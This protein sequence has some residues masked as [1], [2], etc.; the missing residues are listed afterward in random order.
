L[1]LAALSQV[2]A[3]CGGGDS[4]GMFPAVRVHP[5]V[6][7][8]AL[9]HPLLDAQH[10]D[11]YV[12][13][14][15]QT[16]IDV[17]AEFTLTTVGC[18]TSND[19]S[20]RDSGVYWGAYRWETS[21]TPCAGGSL[22]ELD[23]VTISFHV[24]IWAEWYRTFLSGDLDVSSGQ[25]RRINDD[26]SSDRINSAMDTG[27]PGPRVDRVALLHSEQFSG[28]EVGHFERVFSRSHTFE[29]DGG[30]W[31]VRQNLPGN[32]LTSTG[33]WLT[34]RISLYVTACETNN[35][36]ACGDAGS[37]IAFKPP[38]QSSYLGEDASGLQPEPGVGSSGRGLSA[39]VDLSGWWTFV[40][41][42]DDAGPVCGDE[43]PYE[44]QVIIVHTNES[45]TVSGLGDGS[46]AWQ[47]TFDGLTA[48]FSG[49]RTED[50]AEGGGITD[51][52]FELDLDTTG[53]VL[54]G[55]EFWSW[56]NADEGL[57]CSDKTSVVTAERS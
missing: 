2:A 31:F 14:D 12:A 39:A 49:D 21:T 44:R 28:V 4:A 53:T 54:A 15:D 13:I 20:T 52:T 38:P 3:F 5:Y 19:Q 17:A 22:S 46:E 36:S 55:T 40:I 18:P 6:E 41:D 26:R 42:P 45:L 51:M 30:S 1:L 7:T 9:S 29:I 24:E 10:D 8:E 25:P 23:E 50:T 16:T 56:S 27:E 37:V 35:G 11:V 43:D 33:M 32:I 47:G 57:Q 34:P 48:V